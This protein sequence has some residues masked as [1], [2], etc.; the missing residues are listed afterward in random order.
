MVNWLMFLFLTHMFWE[1]LIGHFG[2]AIGNRC[3]TRVWKDSW[4]QQLKPYGQ[5]PEAA[6]NLTVSDLLTTDMQWNK[7]RIEELLPNLSSQIQCLRPGHMQQKKTYLSGSISS[8]VY[9]QQGPD[10]VKMKVFLWSIV[11]QALPFGEN[12]LYM[13]IRER[14]LGESPV[15]TDSSHSY[16]SRCQ[17]YDNRIFDRHAAFHNKNIQ[18]HPPLDLLVAL[19]STKP[20]HLRE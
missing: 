15:E 16:R 17:R 6:L 1:P 20:P 14:S 5:I 8:R 13:P 7:S 12:L 19:D 9:T 3:T 10:I 2:K 4:N 11:Q 18:N